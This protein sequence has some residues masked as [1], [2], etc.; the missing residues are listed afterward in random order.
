MLQ[1]SDGH[2]KRAWQAILLVVFMAVPLSADPAQRP[3]PLRHPTSRP[4]GEGWTSGP[5]VDANA[6]RRT[7]WDHPYID[8]EAANSMDNL[9]YGNLDALAPSFC[10]G[11]FGLG[12]GG[13]GG[14]GFCYNTGWG[15]L[16]Y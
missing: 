8:V 9:R 2:G 5:L 4:P 11:G 13:S 6:P 12:W 7:A 14:F 3:Q 16:P 15:G 1:R 10:F